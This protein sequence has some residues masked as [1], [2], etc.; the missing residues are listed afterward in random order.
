[1]LIFV[2]FVHMH[3]CTDYNLCKYTKVHKSAQKVLTYA[4]LC[5][6]IIKLSDERA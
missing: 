2:K 1:M 5:G 3:I 6:I 4:I